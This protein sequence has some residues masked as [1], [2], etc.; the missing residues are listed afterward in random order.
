MKTWQGEISKDSQAKEEEEPLVRVV[1]L[2]KAEEKQIVAKV[3]VP[4]SVRVFNDD[5]NLKANRDMKDEEESKGGEEFKSMTSDSNHYQR[6]D[7]RNS[8]GA[9]E[10][11][12]YRYSKW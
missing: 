3:E 9:E 7:R 2:S 1:P 10:K 5:R 6:Y 8:Y 11:S 12:S 4:S